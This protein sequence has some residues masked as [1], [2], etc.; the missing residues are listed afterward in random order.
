MGSLWKTGQR[1]VGADGRPT[2]IEWTETTWNPTTGCDRTS[3]GCDNCGF[4]AATAE[5]MKRW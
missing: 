3:H 1:K 4:V 2:G 5:T